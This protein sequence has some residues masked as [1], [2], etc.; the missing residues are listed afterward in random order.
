MPMSHK[1]KG[2]QQQNTTGAENRKSKDEQHD[3]RKRVHIDGGRVVVDLEQDLINKYD[4]GQRQQSTDSRKQF[5]VR[6]FGPVPATHAKI[7]WKPTL[8]GEEFRTAHKVPDLPDEIF[9]TETFYLTG[10]IGREVYQ[11]VARREKTL[12]IIIKIEYDGPSEHYKY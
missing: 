9:P 6:N 7:D 5:I 3:D 11:E 8:N 10:T 2:K 4:T 1:P 12:D